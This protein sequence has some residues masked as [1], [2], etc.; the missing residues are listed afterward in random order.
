MHFFFPVFDTIGAP[1]LAGLAVLFFVM[2]TFFVLRVRKQPRIKRLKTNVGVALFA[3]IGLRLLLLP[4][5]VAAAVWAGSQSFGL[6]HWIALPS[7]AGYIISF[8]LLDYSNYLWHILNHYIPFLWRFHNVHHIDLDLDITTAWRFHLGEII[9]SV[10]FRGGAIILIGVPPILVIIYE[11]VFEAATAFHHSNWRLPFRLERIL[12]WLI[13]TPRMHGIHHS[14]VQRETN[15]NFSTIFSFWDRIHRT[16]RLNIAQDTIIIGVP[17]Y[18]DPKEQSVINLLTL[19]FKRQRK[20]Q[21][22]DGN[23]P[24]RDQRENIGTMEK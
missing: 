19:P 11:I 12:S 4:L 9:A 3:V 23:I 10:L 8:L 14:I 17:S 20:W 18:M 2:E 13:V 6:I 22:P 21:F 24:E 1:V 16:I 7:M 5:M 15:S